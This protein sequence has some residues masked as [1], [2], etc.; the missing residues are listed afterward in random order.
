MIN[1]IVFN[2]KNWFTNLNLFIIWFLARE[3]CIRS[4]HKH[5]LC[6]VGHRRIH[7]IPSNWTT[8][9]SSSEFD[10]NISQT[11]LDRIVAGNRFLFG[12]QHR[13][14]FS[15]DK[16]AH[17]PLYRCSQLLWT[18][19]CLLLVAS[20]FNV[21]YSSVCWITAIGT[22]STFFGCFVYDL[23]Y[24]GCS[25]WNYF[26]HFV[27]RQRP[28]K[29]VSIGWRLEISCC[30][31]NLWMDCCNHLLFLYIVIH[32]WI[33]INILWSSSNCHRRLWYHTSS[34]QW[35]WKCITFYWK[36]SI[37][38]RDST[39]GT[40]IFHLVIATDRIHEKDKLW[41]QLHHIRNKWYLKYNKQWLMKQL[42]LNKLFCLN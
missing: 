8:D 26:S 19:D 1:L 22:C 39:F 4:I 21:Q 36:Y 31:L 9:L 27:Q 11:E 25:D 10:G 40:Y 41:K 33:Q 12:M 32:G 7:S 23:L 3:L 28:T 6:A 42:N 20:I 2:L 17:R 29:V 5:G 24:R 13:C 34:C 35:A 14:Q 18:W 38:S 37:L 16:C 15:R 30:K